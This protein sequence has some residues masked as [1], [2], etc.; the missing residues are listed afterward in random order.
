M[1][2][3]DWLFKQEVRVASGPG[4]I[5]RQKL[6][7]LAAV[8]MVVTAVGGWGGRSRGRAEC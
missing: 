5:K 6:V 2:E 3:S 8:V 4:V 1:L 7:D